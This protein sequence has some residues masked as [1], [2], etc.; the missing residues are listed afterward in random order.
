MLAPANPALAARL[1]WEDASVSHYNNGILGEV[2]NAIMVS[3]A[4]V[5]KD[6]RTVCQMAINMIPTD[7]MYHSVVSNAWKA[8]EK[9]G[10]WRDAWLECDDTYKEYC[11]IHAY[12]NAAAEVVALYFAD[13]DYDRLVSIIAMCGLDVD[14]NA[15]QVANVPAVMYGSDCL[16][17]K[18]LDPIGN[19]MA[20]YVRGMET[21]RF[22]ALAERTSEAILRHRT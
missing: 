8:C 15:A 22:K 21:V 16:D 11:W 4:F 19:Q 9:H 17:R 13:N 6:F 1:A 2:F 14:C 12:P 10:N 3:L 20:T 7:S 5:E 18:W